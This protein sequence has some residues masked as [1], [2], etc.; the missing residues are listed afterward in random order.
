MDFL[1]LMP[2]YDCWPLW[3]GKNSHKV[4]NVNPSTLKLSKSLIK[5]L[6]DWSDKFNQILDRTDPLKSTFSSKSELISFEING[7]KLWKKLKDELGSAFTISYYSIKLQKLFEQMIDY[8][9]N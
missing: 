1:K 6:S 3:W 9:E 4:G 5:E 7:V 2:D 8:P